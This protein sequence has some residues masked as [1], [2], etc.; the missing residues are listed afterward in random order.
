MLPE[1]LF[2]L[3]VR[4]RDAWVVIAMEQAPTIV[5][6]HLQEVVQ[7]RLERTAMTFGHPDRAQHPHKVPY[8]LGP[9]LV[10]GIGQ[11]VCRCSH[12]AVGPA[13]RLPQFS[14]LCY[15]LRDDALHL[16]QF[17]R[18]AP[19]I[20]AADFGGHCDRTTGANC[21]NPLPGANF[22]P[23]FSTRND[24]SVGCFWQEG[25]AY[26][27]GTKNTFGGTSTAEFGPLL[28]LTYPGAPFTPIHRTNDFRKVL[29][30]NPCRAGG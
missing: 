17:G 19:W 7:R 21:V 6:C 18:S 13:D 2:Q 15:G 3:I 4:A 5:V 9:R 29:S 14:C 10:V 23:L 22:Y 12:P 28:F 16:A 20:E 1:I 26:I 25:G 27:P 8:D 11:H 30:N 24:D